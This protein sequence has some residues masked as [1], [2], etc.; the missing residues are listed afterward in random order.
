VTGPPPEGERQ[1]RK[2]KKYRDK[3]DPRVTAKY[4]IKALIGRGNFSKVVRVEHKN[5]K[6][7]YAI[8]M[9]DRLEGKEVFESEVAQVSN[10]DGLFPVHVNNEHLP[11]PF[12]KLW[13]HLFQRMIL[14]L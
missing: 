6:Q 4:D 10:H 1:H 14:W 3:F 11:T 5:T 2:V 7:P 13:L 8:K 12:L 9:I